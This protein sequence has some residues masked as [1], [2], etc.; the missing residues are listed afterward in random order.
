MAVFCVSL[1]KLFTTIY[2][3]RMC[4]KRERQRESSYRSVKQCKNITLLYVVYCDE[5][6]CSL[7]Y[8]ITEKSY[9]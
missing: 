2:T 3:Q 8:A 9:S 6:V 1:G 4:S 5:V 7:M